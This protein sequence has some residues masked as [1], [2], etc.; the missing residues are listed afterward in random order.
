ML[1]EI[2]IDPDPLYKQAEEIEK[3]IKMQMQEAKPTQ[4]QL[5]Q[6]PTMMYG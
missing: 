4:P 1:P 5:F 3:Q 6:E 2:E